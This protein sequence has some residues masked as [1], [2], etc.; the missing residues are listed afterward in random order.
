MCFF[1]NVIKMEISIWLFVLNLLYKLEL[2]SKLSTPLF[3]NLIKSSEY[4]VSWGKRML[5]VLINNDNKD[6]PNSLL[7]SDC[8]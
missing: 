8:Y 3:V 6:K 4:Y 2:Y 1:W 7:L 5:L